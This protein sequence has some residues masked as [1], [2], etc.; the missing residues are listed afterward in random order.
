MSDRTSRWQI[1][2]GCIVLTGLIGLGDYTLTSAEVT[3]TLL[4]LAPVVIA[5][6]FAGTVF[7]AIVAVLATIVCTACLVAGFDAAA[8]GWSAGGTLTMFLLVAYLLG[9]VRGYVEQERRQRTLAVEQLRHAERL[10]V[11]GTLAA[12][13]AHELGTPLNVIS[14]SA[15]LL[16]GATER[17][18]DD[19]SKVI[20]D[21]T[22]RI[23]AIIRHLLEFG[24]RA[25]GQQADV[26]LNAIAKASIELLSSTARKR[27]CSILF[28]PAPEAVPVHAN[29]SEIEQVLSNL[30]LNGVQAMQDGGEVRVRVGHAT[31]LDRVGEARRFATVSIVDRGAGI[32]P[33]DL[34]KIFDP[35]FTTKGVGEG[36]GLGLSVSFGIV[37]DHGGFIDVDSTLGRGTTF[38]VLLPGTRLARSAA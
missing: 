2:V 19:L 4:Y 8:I 32:A 18:V 33:D 34:P 15:E 22:A 12:G 14:G 36:T 35:F 28:E 25:G 7:G 9:R 17:D 24:R 37:Q 20:R 1:V 21:Q 6:W 13:V 23:G 31:R 26:D 29:V 16:V 27:S 11:I 3:F 30:L 10:N 38:T 5:T